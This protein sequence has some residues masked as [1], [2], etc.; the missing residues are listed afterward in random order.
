MLLRLL[1]I[2]LI[3]SNLI[4]ANSGTC[5]SINNELIKFES[6]SGIDN[7]KSLFEIIRQ[8]HQT[9]EN[10]DCENIT[11]AKNLLA[12]QLYNQSK[13]IEARKLLLEAEQIF[14]KNNLR[15]A[16]Y[17]VNQNYLGLIDILDGNLKKATF[18]FNRCKKYAEQLND[19]NLIC[20]SYLQLGLVH[21]EMQ[22]YAKAESFYAK[23]IEINKD[24]NNYEYE[25]YSYQNLARIQLFQNDKDLALYY[26]KEAYQVWKHNKAYKGQYFINHILSEIYEAKGENDKAIEALEQSVAL[27]KTHGFNIYIE[28]I[29]YRLGKASYENG[30]KEAAK[31]YFLSAL[32]TAV[33]LDND[34]QEELLNKLVDIHNENNDREGLKEML[35]LVV[36]VLN[37]AKDRNKVQAD[38]IISSQSELDNTNE[39]NQALQQSY[40]GE[41]I[42]FRR[43]TLF[44][45]ALIALLASAAY[46]IYSKTKES[47]KRKK[48][49]DQ[50]KEQ[51]TELESANEKLIEFT[52]IISEQNLE[53]TIKNKDLKNFTYAASHDLKTPLRTIVSFAG[54]L[55][56]KMQTH[57]NSVIELLEL[58]EKGG[59]NMSEMVDN[60]LAYAKA[61]S[62]E[63]KIE[64]TNILNLVD[65][66][67]I[68]LNA[69]I[70]E[71][72]ASINK[73]IHID[74]A[75]IDKTCVQQ[76]LSNLIANSIKYSKKHIPPQIDISVDETDKEY[77]FEVKDNGL[78]IPQEYL[79]RVF[80]MFQRVPTDTK[81]EG[82]GIGLAT[83]KRLID[84]NKG[85][86]SVK[87]KLGEGSV[88]CF[89][90][91]KQVQKIKELKNDRAA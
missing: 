4:S 54:M 65:L 72:K 83:C 49:L 80:D 28:E 51:K 76:V 35:S 27:N 44:T 33:N 36:N 56:S 37:D 84:L 61:G 73:N 17:I 47:N 20:Q 10:F 2:F 55:K 58:I 30:E 32:N 31:N 18:H 79:D 90:L 26:A 69:L 75:F 53:L 40:L 1:I 6:I 67:I 21:L 24:L 87:S 57:D 7:T 66:V 64:K 81:V 74:S 22:E 62:K 82:T 16:D 23:C 68:N 85:T 34:I 15:D 45:I 89:S 25:G 70:Q 42:K 38:R 19:T 71:R 59:K 9:T 86:I 50:I 43:L 39:L 3:F 5:D 77:I 41:E 12:Y 29:Y 63:I 11:K 88:F 13:L 78:G 48:L 46:L 52:D 8:L 60:L 14:N 91:P